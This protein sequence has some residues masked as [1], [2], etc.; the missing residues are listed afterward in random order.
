MK[1]KPNKMTSRQAFVEYDFVAE[2]IDEM[3]CV[4]GDFLTVYREDER[5]CEDWVFATKGDGS[6]VK[7]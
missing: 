5:S 7:L 1:Y 2:N 4:T 6:E 3:T